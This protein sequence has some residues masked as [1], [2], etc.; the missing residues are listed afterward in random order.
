MNTSGTYTS[1]T[2]TSGTSDQWE[3]PKKTVRKSSNQ[4]D[5]MEID[6]V[7]RN[8]FDPLWEDDADAMNCSACNQSERFHRPC[9]DAINGRTIAQDRK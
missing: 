8:Q 7:D 2:N 6:V 1:G 3:T 4:G 9:I 5:K